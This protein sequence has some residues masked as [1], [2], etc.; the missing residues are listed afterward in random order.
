[1]DHY[2]T[3]CNK[4]YSSYKSL[5]NH[6]KI[7]HNKI[8][9]K[10]KEKNEKYNRINEKNGKYN[11]ASCNKQF[12][13]NI[14][15]DTH[16]KMEC[17]PDV[18][19]NN[20]FTFKINTFGKN[21]YP[22]DNGGDI[23]I[24]QTEFNLKNY[25]KIGVTTNIY[26]RMSDYRCG[27]VLEPRI[28]CYFPIKN[29]KKADIILKQK[30]QKYNLKREIYKCENLEEIKQ[31]IKSIQKEFKSDIF[32]VKPEIKECDVCECK[33]CDEIFTNRYELSIHLNT[34]EYTP[35]TQTDNSNK[36]LECNYCNKL[37]SRSDNLHRHIHTCKVK[38]S[39]KIKLKKENKMLKNELNNIKN[40]M[41]EMQI[42][43]QKQL[44][45]LLNQNKIH[46]GSKNNNALDLS[47]CTPKTLN[48]NCNNNSNNKIINNK[49]VNFDCVDISKG[50][51]EKEIEGIIN[52]KLEV[53]K[54]VHFN[55]KL[56]E[57]SNIY[58]TNMRYN[59]AYIFNGTSFI[60]VSKNEVINDL[61][62]NWGEEIELS[63]DIYKNKLSEHTVKRLE[64]FLEQLNSEDKFVDSS[65][66]AYS[67]YKL[68][69]VANIKRLIYDNSDAKKFLLLNKMDLEEKELKN[70]EESDSENNI[71]L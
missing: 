20:V 13:S 60:T 31:I 57:Y 10:I 2:C 17:K 58:I 4:I 61:I 46:S 68:Y 70:T 47:K 32:E 56:P 45:N 1:M 30:L 43:I 65:N 64:V 14:E 44:I 23:Y 11:C 35:T 22:N 52:K 41:M 36:K 51:S 53:I 39:N 34:C 28:H 62:N 59:N 27:A 38:L 67:N 63:F 50:L 6:N 55:E 26:S 18:N 8:N 21:K 5:W 24:V 33:Y 29:I 71:N 48:K 7:F 37:Y 16:I 49:Y 25:Y 19:H 69:K 9:N 15:L 40:D 3:I 42:E 12:I 66:K 54:L